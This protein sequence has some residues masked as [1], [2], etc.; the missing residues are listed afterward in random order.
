MP[1]SDYGG[2]VA[3]LTKQF[4]KGLLTAIES[5]AIAPKTVE[6]IVFAGLDDCAARA[7][8][9]IG[10]VAFLKKHAF[11]RQPIHVRRLIDF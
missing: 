5:Q 3:S 6:V 4:G 8:D 1:F 10:D 9:G 2:G 7:A 11:I